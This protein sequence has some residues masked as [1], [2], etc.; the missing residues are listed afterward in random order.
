MFLPFYADSELL[1]GAFL[2]LIDGKFK[3]KYRND[4]QIQTNLCPFL[5]PFF[6]SNLGVFC[7]NLDPQKGK[8]WPAKVP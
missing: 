5:W 4:G 8:I 1:F 7:E 2:G 3:S 6:A